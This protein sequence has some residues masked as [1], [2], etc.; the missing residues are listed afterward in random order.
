[1]DKIRMGK[2]RVGFISD[3]KSVFGARLLQ[4]LKMLCIV[5]EGWRIYLKQKPRL[6]E[7]DNEMFWLKNVFLQGHTAD[8]VWSQLS[9]KQSD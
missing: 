1:M 9:Q 5:Q 7:N 4:A 8:L 2:I 6:N 3:I